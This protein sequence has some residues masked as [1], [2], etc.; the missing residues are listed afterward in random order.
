MKVKVTIKQHVHPSK[1]GTTL[2]VDTMDAY[3]VG[4]LFVQFIITYV[5]NINKVILFVKPRLYFKV[6]PATVYRSVKVS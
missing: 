3:T 2:T 1:Q 4:V 6:L 5:F